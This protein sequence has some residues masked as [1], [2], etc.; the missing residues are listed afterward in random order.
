MNIFS[1]Y[2][3]EVR[4]YIGSYK[5]KITGEIKINDKQGV[6][7]LQVSE[8]DR[9]I[10]NKLLAE[11]R[12]KFYYL[13]IEV[14]ENLVEMNIKFFAYEKFIAHADFLEEFRATLA[15]AL[16]KLNE[17]T[18]LVANINAKGMFLS[19]KEQQNFIF[20]S[21]ASMVEYKIIEKVA[22][23]GISEILLHKIKVYGITML[24]TVLIIYT[25]Y[26]LYAYIPDHDPNKLLVKVL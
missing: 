22:H 18:Q 16:Q 1:A 4:D 13:K 17:S 11:L 2:I 19:P 21:K 3:N 24:F 12:A 26:C 14:Q 10:I 23:N 15:L 20:L 8:E 9:S 5:L 6:N 25:L 7:L